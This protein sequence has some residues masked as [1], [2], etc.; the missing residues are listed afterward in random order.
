MDTNTSCAGAFTGPSRLSPVEADVVAYPLPPAS[1]ARRAQSADRDIPPV[2]L[3]AQLAPDSGGA[4]R[5]TSAPVRN[6]QNKPNHP[7][8]LIPCIQSEVYPT[9]GQLRRYKRLLKQKQ[10]ETGWKHTSLFCL[11]CRC[12]FRGAAAAG[13]G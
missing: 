11:C 1:S 6:K 4:C 7:E 2:S 8:L 5:R 10:I 9:K 13:G 3:A 12:A